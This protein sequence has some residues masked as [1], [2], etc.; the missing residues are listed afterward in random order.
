MP[1]VSQ[2]ESLEDAAPEFID[3]DYD[4]QGSIF[5]ETADEHFFNEL[6]SRAHSSLED[7]AE[8]SDVTSPASTK[9]TPACQPT[10]SGPPSPSRKDQEDAIAN[11]V[12]CVERL[13]IKYAPFRNL[14]DPYPVVDWHTLARPNLRDRIG[15]PKPNQLPIHGCSHDP[16]LYF[17]TFSSSHSPF[18]Y[19]LGYKT[20]LGPV[21]MPITSINGFT[22]SQ[23]TSSW[24][25]SATTRPRPNRGCRGGRR[26]WPWSKR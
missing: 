5:G 25:I 15:L 12:S 20:T 6:F 2:T 8:N 10:P 11:L 24:V 21:S 19:H 1:L 14:P 16:D 22:F 13:A 17:T 4:D 7:H 18:G 23:E 9:A 26:T 3:D